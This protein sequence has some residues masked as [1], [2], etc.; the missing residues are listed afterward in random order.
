VTWAS[1][2]VAWRGAPLAADVLPADATRPSH[3]MQAALQEHV[4][5]LVSASQLNRV[6][7]ALGLSSEA[8]GVKHACLWLRLRCL[9]SCCMLLSTLPGCSTILLSRW[10]LGA[11]PSGAGTIFPTLLGR[12]SP[13][14]GTLGRAHSPY[15]DGAKPVKQ[16]LSSQQADK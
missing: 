3:V 6:R 13:P 10:H 11:G 1:E 5:L 8:R 4:G 9:V 16:A 14:N 7:N 15:E 12:R 2:Q